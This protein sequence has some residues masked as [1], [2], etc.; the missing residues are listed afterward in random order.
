M[1]WNLITNSNWEYSDT[2]EIDDPIN[3]HNYANMN[4][5]SAGIRTNSYDGTEVYVYCR[6]NDRT[7]GIGYGELKK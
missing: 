2:P 5:L 7:H 6:R 3:A 4:G 1:A